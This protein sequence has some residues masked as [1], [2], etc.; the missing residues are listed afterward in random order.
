METITYA[1]HVAV[2]H[3]VIAGGV[4]SEIFWQFSNGKTALTCNNMF[5]TIRDG[6][7]HVHDTLASAGE[8]T[9]DA[10]DHD[11]HPETVMELIG[12]T[13]IVEIV[14]TDMHLAVSDSLIFDIIL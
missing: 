8:H 9:R 13:Q 7:Y 5:Q 14:E 10:R 4:P 11:P 2:R 12:E 6:A 1:I 3:P